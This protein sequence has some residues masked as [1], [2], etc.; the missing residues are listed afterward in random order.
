MSESARLLHHIDDD[1]L[2]QPVRPAPRDP[3]DLLA[4]VIILAIALFLGVFA[5]SG[6]DGSVL[7][8]PVF[9]LVVIALLT[10]SL[11]VS[12]LVM[13]GLIVLTLSNAWYCDNNGH[14]GKCA[15]YKDAFNVAL[16]GFSL[17]LSWLVWAAFNL[18]LAVDKSRLGRRLS[19]L[20][21]QRFG[22]SPYSLGPSLI[23][24]EL[25]AALLIP[26]NTA[27]GGALIFPL[28]M[29]INKTIG[30][31][32]IERYLILC[33]LHANLISSSALLYGTVGNPVVTDAAEEIFGIQF[34]YGE[35]ILGACVPIAV[36]SF[37]IPYVSWHLAG[38]ISASEYDS[39]NVLASSTAELKAMG[40]L[41]SAELATCVIVASCLCGWVA[42]IFPDGLVALIGLTVMIFVGI[43]DWAD[44]RDNGQAWDSFF[45]LAGMVLIVEQMNKLGLSHIIGTWCRDF[46]VSGLDP[47]SAALVIGVFYFLTMYLF[48]SITS[49]IVALTEPLLEAGKAAGCPPYLM[50]GIIGY[51]SGLSACLTSYSSG[52]VVMYFSQNAFSKR[53][54]HMIGALIALVYIGVFGTFGIGWWWLIGW[55]RQ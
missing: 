40:K 15:T 1:G 39:E 11:P 12:P 52:I 7:V 18:G 24:I 31:P 46:L 42:N 37:M 19:L 51:S 8:V 33:G 3:I 49:H 9:A 21:I 6:L 14:G 25:V 44:V 43:L 32:V 27:R 2:P 30:S 34:G 20:I 41:S 38:S 53:E 48:S 54:W 55:L 13:S 50:T 29:S 47:I 17:S 10:T 45:W 16:D 23:F 26:S 36:L 35:W 4:V 22:T 28:V 5:A